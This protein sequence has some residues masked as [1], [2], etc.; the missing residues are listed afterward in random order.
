MKNKFKYDKLMYHFQSK[1]T[2]PVSFNG[3][4]RP[5]GLLRRIKDGSIDLEKAKEFKKNLD[6][7]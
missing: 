3:F 4:N 5:L 6:K 2:I 1:I 7:I